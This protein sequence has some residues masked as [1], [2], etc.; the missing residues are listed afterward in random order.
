[1]GL[2]NFLVRRQNFQEVNT[3]IPNTHN[4]TSNIPLTGSLCFSHE[5]RK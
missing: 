2:P 5:Q 3:I 1:M 4:H